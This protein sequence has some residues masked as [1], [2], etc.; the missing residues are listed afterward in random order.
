MSSTQ[1]A[2]QT[3]GAVGRDT[4]RSVSPVIKTADERISERTGMSTGALL[5]QKNGGR[6]SSN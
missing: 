1:V 3:S 2:G 4:M 6:L 5:T